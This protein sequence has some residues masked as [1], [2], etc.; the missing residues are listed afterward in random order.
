MRI[1]LAIVLL[2]ALVLFAV[3]RPAAA[4]SKQDEARATVEAVLDRLG[5]D[6]SRIKSIYLAPEGFSQDRPVQSYVGWVSFTDCQGN[7]V[8]D[9]GATEAVRTIYTTGDCKV[10]GVD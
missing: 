9:L 7:L 2:G 5:V 6:R 8:I 10:P 1:V 4:S 3:A